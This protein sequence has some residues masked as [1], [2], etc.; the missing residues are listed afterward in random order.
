MKLLRDKKVVEGLQ[1]LI[2]K[3][4]VNNKPLPQQCMVHKVENIK[5]MTGC[6]MRLAA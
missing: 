4:N 6:E 1:E 2:D 5:K 3:F